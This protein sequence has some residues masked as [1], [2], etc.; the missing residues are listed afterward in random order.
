MVTWVN[1]NQD[2]YTRIW[3]DSVYYNCSTPGGNDSGAM[4]GQ[5]LPPYTIAYISTL[6]VVQTSIYKEKCLY[7]MAFN[8]IK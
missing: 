4:V 3:D 8:E 6:I 1:R 7:I 5:L 2:A